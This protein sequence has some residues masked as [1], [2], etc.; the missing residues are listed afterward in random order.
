MNGCDLS[1]H[2][3]E[4]D[5]NVG[6]KIILLRL[7]YRTFFFGIYSLS[8]VITENDRESFVFRSFPIAI[9]R[10]FDCF[11]LLSFQNSIRFFV[12]HS[13]V[14]HSYYRDT[15]KTKRKKNANNNK[16]KIPLKQKKRKE[17]RSTWQSV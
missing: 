13:R 4:S 16:N 9:A 15:M 17:K 14:P 5:T 12:C 6:N 1:S 2:F 8:N 3:S 7:F 11:V 10:T